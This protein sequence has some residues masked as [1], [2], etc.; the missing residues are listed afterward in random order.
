MLEVK[1]MEN[2]H[3]LFH[4]QTVI[5]YKNEVYNSLKKT[6][7]SMTDNEILYGD[8]EEWIQYYFDKYTIQ[9]ITIYLDNITRTLS[10]TVVK[11]RNGWFPY[12]NGPEF[13]ERPGYEIKYKI[14]YSGDYHLFCLQPNTKIVDEYPV[15]DFVES[16]ENECGSFCLCM[17]F[18]IQDLPKENDTAKAYVERHFNERFENYKTM[19]NQINL[20]ITPFN[21]SLREVVEDLLNSRKNRAKH[22]NRLCNLLNIPLK[23]NPDAPNIDPVPLKLI[24]KTYPKPP[25]VTQPP[26]E[27]CITDQDY[28]YILK[29]IHQCCT[30]M[31]EIARTSNK[32][33]EEELRDLILAMLST[34]YLNNAGGETFRRKGKTDILIRYENR[35]A[36]IA[37]CKV[38]HGIKHFEKAV[39]QLFGYSTWKDIKVSVIIFNKTNKDFPSILKTIQVWVERNTVRHSQ[40]KENCW[41]CIIHEEKRKLDFKVAI[42][43]YDLSI[44]S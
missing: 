15:S 38:W 12:D 21:S 1:G 7:E 18:A 43:V 3:I 39:K 10:D 40:Q 13:Y 24:K 44:D 31:E 14:P 35:A 16:K 11:V 4:N 41:K 29:V 33:E 26:T 5:D 37:E 9:P 36:F 42:C 22:K 6:I 34:H 28:E 2:H 32:F 20:E 8:F 30:V 19:I 17:K 23:M 27:Y 25:G